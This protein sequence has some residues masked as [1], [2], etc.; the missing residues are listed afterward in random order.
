MFDWV[1]KPDICR[2]DR[3]GLVRTVSGLLWTQTWTPVDLGVDP[4]STATARQ[5]PNVTKPLHFGR[6]SWSPNWD[7]LR[8]RPPKRLPSRT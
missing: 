6:R 2:A 7:E 8:G 1:R 5:E 3:F 4:A